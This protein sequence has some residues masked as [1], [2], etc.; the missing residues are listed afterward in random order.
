MH[1]EECMVPSAS[2]LP[3]ILLARLTAQ[4]NASPDLNPGDILS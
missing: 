1:Q 3:A 2:M 4:L